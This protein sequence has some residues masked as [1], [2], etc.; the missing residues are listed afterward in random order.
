MAM[1]SIK[2]YHCF[3]ICLPDFLSVFSVCFVFC[4]ARM[5]LAKTTLR[6]P[7]SK[8]LAL[9]SPTAPLIKTGS[10]QCSCC[11]KFYF[12]GWMPLLSLI[13]F[14]LESPSLSLSNLRTV[15]HRLH[16]ATYNAPNHYAPNNVV[17]ANDQLINR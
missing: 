15:N 9:S 3:I 1:L 2:E 13:L 11:R 5:Q 8:R 7:W 10:V 14:S 12:A 16:T 4:C 17:S 6:A